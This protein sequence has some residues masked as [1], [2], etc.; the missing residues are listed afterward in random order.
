MQDE[1]DRVL[2]S[3]IYDG[4]R[5][6][7]LCLASFPETGRGLAATESIRKDEILLTIPPRHILNLKVVGKE[8]GF[9][10]RKYVLPSHT[11]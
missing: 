1:H 4:I 2:E 9:D 10:W 3:L 7:K 6:N 5:I 8:F 11:P